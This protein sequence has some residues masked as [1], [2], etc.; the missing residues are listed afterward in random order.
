MLIIRLK[1]FLVFF[2]F[3]MIGL[4]VFY[5]SIQEVIEYY[6]FH[7]VI[8]YSW[9]DCF[10]LLFSFF[11]FIF[12][13]YP[14]YVAFYGITIPAGR[15]KSFYKAALFFFVM[16]LV[17][18]IIF[19]FIYVNKI[20]SKGYIRCQGIPSGWMPGMATKY[21]TSELLCSKKDP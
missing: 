19:S 17:V 2:I 8:I 14:G 16:S 6:D 9:L 3:L 1:A 4:T 13:V 20:E 12:S 18:P 15:S 10:T 11:I 7:E 21:A 5:F